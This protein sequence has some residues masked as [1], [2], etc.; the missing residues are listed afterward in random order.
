MT[1]CRAWEHAAT[2]NKREGDQPE[3][4]AAKEQRFEDVTMD[5]R[6]QDVSVTKARMD[7]MLMD[8]VVAESC[9]TSR[10]HVNEEKYEPTTIRGLPADLFKK[11][12]AR[13]MKDL[14]DMNVLEWVRESTV[15]R[16][17]MI[18]DCGWAMKM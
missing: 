5:Q 18:L 11:V 15:P 12:Q 16:D 7:E 4:L 13:E 10:V 17:A 3:E 8:Q 2:Q 9:G 14:D 1:S 6:P